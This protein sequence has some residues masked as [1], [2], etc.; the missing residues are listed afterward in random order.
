[1]PILYKILII[2]LIIINVTAFTA[3]GLDKQKA[4]K[5][6]WRIPERTLLVL[7]FAGGSLGALCGM[8]LFHH[9]TQKMKFVIGVPVMIALHAGIAYY[10][11]R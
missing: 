3:Y 2:Y 4:K 11:F 9:K 7:A 8:Y 10:I 1:M 5:D 6:K